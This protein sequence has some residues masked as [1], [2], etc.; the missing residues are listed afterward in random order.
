MR[1]KFSTKGK[2]YVATEQ[3]IFMDNGATV[4]FIEKGKDEPLYAQ[5]VHITQKEWQRIK[6]QLSAIDYEQYYGR[7]PLLQGV[8]IYQVKNGGN[9]ETT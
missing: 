6:P 2:N 1:L 9:Y 4:M 3:S 8:S 7:K 5:R